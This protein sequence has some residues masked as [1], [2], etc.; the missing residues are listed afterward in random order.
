MNPKPSHFSLLLFTLIWQPIYGCSLHIKILA[1]LA[2]SSNK[3]MI[4]TLHTPCR[5][6]NAIRLHSCSSSI[7]ELSGVNKDIQFPTLLYIFLTTR[8]SN[9]TSKA[10]FSALLNRNACSQVWQ[11]IHLCMHHDKICVYVQ[12]IQ[13]SVSALLIR[14]A[15]S[16]FGKPYTCTPQ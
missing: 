2:T 7:S 3:S 14:N 16:Q 15:C 9:S 11:T 10:S 6:E 4:H 8:F 1:N 13:A 5:A 12:V